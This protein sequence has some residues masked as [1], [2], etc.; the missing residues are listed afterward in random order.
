MINQVEKTKN[1]REK[2]N[3]EERYYRVR[4][5][6]RKVE[7]II[8]KLVHLIKKKDYLSPFQN[9]S[10]HLLFSQPNPVVIFHPFIFF[11]YI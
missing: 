6:E 10:L 7:K 9:P 8:Q 11:L 2:K 4:K 5:R 1:S 3:L